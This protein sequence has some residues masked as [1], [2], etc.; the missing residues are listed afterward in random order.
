MQ[1]TVF[2]TSSMGHFGPVVSRIDYDAT[3]LQHFE[4][5]VGR[6]HTVVSRG[7]CALCERRVFAV[8][9]GDSEVI[10]DAY[11]AEDYTGESYG[12]HP[13]AAVVGCALCAHSDHGHMRILAKLQ[14]QSLLAAR[15]EQRTT[16]SL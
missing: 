16:E 11:T 8:I 7:R 13:A 15:K 4:D 5:V 12:L 10:A 3:G 6:M 14:V 2:Q 1:H 9:D